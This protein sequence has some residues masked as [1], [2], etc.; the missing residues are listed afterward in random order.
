MGTTIDH[1]VKLPR[2]SDPDSLL[3]RF[4]RLL[5]LQRQAGATEVL[6]ERREVDAASDRFGPSRLAQSFDDVGLRLEH[7]VAKRVRK[8]LPREPDQAETE[9]VV[10]VGV[11]AARVA[12]AGLRSDHRE[13][14]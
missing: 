9:K 11:D 4:S 1:S 10:E 12:A 8:R 3:A 5:L 14:G 7:L 6:P 2:R 13:A